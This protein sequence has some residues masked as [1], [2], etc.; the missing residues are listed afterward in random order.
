MHHIVMDNL[1]ENLIAKIEN[2]QILEMFSPYEK[3]HYYTGI[4][5]GFRKTASAFSLN[6]E[7][8]GYVISYFSRRIMEFRKRQQ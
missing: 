7:Q 4:L 5:N 1:V 2:R 8:R 6:A 3:M